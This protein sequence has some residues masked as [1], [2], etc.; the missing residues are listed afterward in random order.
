MV[1]LENTVEAHVSAAPHDTHVFVILWVIDFIATLHPD[2][3]LL[4]KR[5]VD[6]ERHVNNP[7]MLLMS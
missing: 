4:N 3:C 6:A 1:M 2:F 5:S 7:S